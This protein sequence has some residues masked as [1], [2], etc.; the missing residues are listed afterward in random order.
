M[1]RSSVF[2][3]EPVM[4]LISLCRNELSAVFMDSPLV[5]PSARYMPVVSMVTA[6]LPRSSADMLCS[7]LLMALSSGAEMMNC[8]PMSFSVLVMTTPQSNVTNR[9]WLPSVLTDALVRSVA[10]MSSRGFM[11]SPVNS[12]KLPSCM[13]KVFSGM[14]GIEYFISPAASVYR[15]VRLR[16]SAL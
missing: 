2:S 6:S 10:V 9:P 13:V 16:P 8:S 1:L 15:P 3:A 11:G 14:M 4:L 5:L 7:S 12:T